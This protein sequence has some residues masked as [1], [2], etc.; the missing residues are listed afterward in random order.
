MNGACNCTFLFA[1]PLGPSEYVNKGQKLLNFNNKVN[2]IV[3]CVLTIKRD[4]TY[5]MGFCSVALGMPQRW[6][7]SVL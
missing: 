1:H 7:L 4:K 2:F 5:R 3:M 6:H